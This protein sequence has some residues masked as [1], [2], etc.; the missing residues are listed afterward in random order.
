MSTQTEVRV[1][2]CGICGKPLTDP[3]SVQFGV[4]PV[5]RINIKLREAKNMTESLFGPRA[6]FTYELR[7]NVVCIVDQDEGR[8][9]TNDVENVLADIARDGVDLREYRVIYRDTLGIWDEIVLTKAGRYKTF[10]SLNARELG[11]ALAKVQAVQ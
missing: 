7:G 2:T 11:E 8:S 4:G 6:A 3:V 10:K 1:C 5:C 9:V